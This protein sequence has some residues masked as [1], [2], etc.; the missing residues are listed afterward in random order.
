MN[1]DECGNEL[2]GPIQH[3]PV[4][5]PAVQCLVI[6]TLDSSSLIRNNICRDMSSSFLLKRCPQLGIIFGTLVL[7]AIF[8]VSH[9]CN[10]KLR[11]NGN[12]LLL[13]PRLNRQYLESI[14]FCWKLLLRPEHNVSE[15]CCSSC[16]K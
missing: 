9:V 7:G 15:A 5:C 16:S 13:L 10:K 1:S 6:N 4:Q 8:Y 11:V 12:G 2:S 3:R 14:V